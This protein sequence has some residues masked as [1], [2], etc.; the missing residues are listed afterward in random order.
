M[1][2]FQKDN[3]PVEGGLN[4]KNMPK[5]QLLVI[6]QSQKSD[7]DVL[8]RKLNE[9]S[10]ISEERNRLAQQVASLSAENESLKS[11]VTELQQRL[12]ASENEV[13]EAGSIAEMSFRVN[14]VLEAAQNA[15]DDYLAKIKAMHDEMSREYSVYEKTSREKA[16]AILA[17][18]NAEADAIRN[19]ARNEANDIWNTLQKRFDSYVT[20]KKQN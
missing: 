12:S 5:D 17:S 13:K 15:A 6:L 19:S 16:E 2:L 18:A 1:A 14:G 9:V 8:N 3:M 7:I 11:K 4:Y 10:S 20:D